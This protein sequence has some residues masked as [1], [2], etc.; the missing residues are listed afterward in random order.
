MIT[1]WSGVPSSMLCL[2]SLRL[3]L[4]YSD[5]EKKRI[6]RSCGQENVNYER[7]VMITFPESLEGAFKKGLLFGGSQVFHYWTI[8]RVFF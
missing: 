3:F 5:F 6:M 8:F 4:A 7:N 2:L 1:T